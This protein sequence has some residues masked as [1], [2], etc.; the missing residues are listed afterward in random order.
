MRLPDTAKSEISAARMSAAG[1]AV[2]GSA[3]GV[4]FKKGQQAFQEYKLTKITN[5]HMKIYRLEVKRT[6][7]HDIEPVSASEPIQIV[8]Y[9]LEHIYNKDEMWREKSVALFLDKKLNIIGQTLVSVGTTDACLMDI[10]LIAKSALESLA[11]GVIIMHNHP[12]G[13]PAPSK[14]DIEETNKIK[15][16]LACLDIELIDHIILGDDRHYSFEKETI[17][18]N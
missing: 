5:R 6:E 16:G 14:H 18:K 11:S 12:S 8:H 10:K 17:A 1:S 7:L 4:T 9:A 3:H 15:R 13:D 2:S